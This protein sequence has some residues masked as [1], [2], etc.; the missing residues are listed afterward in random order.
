MGVDYCH[1]RIMP[2]QGYAQSCCLL[3]G[4]VVACMRH[5]V[6][7]ILSVNLLHMTPLGL[8][9]RIENELSES[10][11]VSENF[12][13]FQVR[14]VKFLKIPDYFPNLK[15]SIVHAG[16]L[17]SEIV[18]KVKKHVATSFP[19]SADMNNDLLYVCYWIRGRIKHRANMVWIILC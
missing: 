8:Q 4:K 2:D 5:P 7:W 16:F 11:A 14:D 3:T 1:R 15:D 9:S 6:L 19:F 12:G 17:G 18:A 10:L 13:E